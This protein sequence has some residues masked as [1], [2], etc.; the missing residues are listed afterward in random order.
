M[1][2]N[3]RTETAI[4]QDNRE[5]IRFRFAFSTKQCLDLEPYF[6]LEKIIWLFS[7]NLWAQSPQISP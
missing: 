2:L 4:D 3:K 6:S 7:L 1:S 5:V